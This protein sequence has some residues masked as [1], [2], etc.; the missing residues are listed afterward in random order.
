MDIVPSLVRLSAFLQR[1]TER[2]AR[3]AAESDSRL[4][5][6]SHR[7]WNDPSN[8]DLRGISHWRG[9][10]P[11]AD[12]DDL[13]LE[14]GRSHLELY[15][16]ATDWAGC[17]QVDGPI[18]E[19][20]AGGGMN[21]VHFAPIATRF[22]AV[23]INAESL[24]ECARQV[25][26]NGGN[27]VVPLQISAGNPEAV[28]GLVGEPVVGIISTYVFECLPTPSAGLRVLRT[29][30]GLLAPGGVAVV[31]FRYRLGATGLPKWRDYKRNWVR[32]TTYGID[33]L[34]TAGQ[35]VGLEPLFVRLAPTSHFNETNYAYLALQR[36]R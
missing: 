34:W 21:A 4:A 35:E 13:W 6:D 30:Y 33:E 26:L 29:M 19:W 24:E 17:G 28:T 23:D 8:D 1:L 27:N 36:P 9:E 18:L 2:L 20:G 7:F 11:F 15:R 10:G 31:H 12:N 16:K 3:I 14:L 32:M 5:S 22:Y 25:R